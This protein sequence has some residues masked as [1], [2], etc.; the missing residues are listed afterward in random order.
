MPGR[1]TAR[2][3]AW[4]WRGVASA[5]AHAVSTGPPR[6]AEHRV[7]V[8][9]LRAVADERLADLG[10]EAGHCSGGSSKGTFRPYRLMRRSS[11]PVAPGLVS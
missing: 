6:L 2:N 8:R 11:L 9:R 10:Y 3:A 1:T 5:V 4:P 7:E